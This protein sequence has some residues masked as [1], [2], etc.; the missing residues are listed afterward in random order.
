RPTSLSYS[1]SVRSLVDSPLPSTLS[2]LATAT[3]SS[4][5][6]VA[7]STANVGLGYVPDRTPPASPVA[8]T[9][10]LA[11]SVSSTLM[12]IPATM[13]SIPPPPPPVALTTGLTG[14]LSSTVIPLPATIEPTFSAN[15]AAVA[16][17]TAKPGFGYWPDSTPPAPPLG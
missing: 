8:L 11:G 6:C 12:P 1:G 4:S 7:M 16:I 3:A 13:E 5:A 2:T 14:S 9:T 15:C 10:G 17:G